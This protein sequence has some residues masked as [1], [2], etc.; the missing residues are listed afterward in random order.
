M[1][2]KK[3]TDQTLFTARREDWKQLSHLD[4]HSGGCWSDCHVILVVVPSVIKQNTR[5][6]KLPI[7]SK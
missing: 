3:F 5:H 6:D 1:Q 2:A 4:W 7:W